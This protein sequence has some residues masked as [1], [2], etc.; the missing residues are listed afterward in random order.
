MVLLRCSHARGF[1]G[2]VVQVYLGALIL[3]A[4]S[5]LKV[6]RERDF[7][8]FESRFCCTDALALDHDEL[9]GPV[10]PSLSVGHG[11][12]HAVDVRLRELS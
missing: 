7:G 5:K 2:R 4:F 3:V 9:C 12:R 8:A 6:A 10:L 11:Q 1:G